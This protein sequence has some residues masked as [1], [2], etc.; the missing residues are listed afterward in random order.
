ML[1][2][3]LKMSGFPRCPAG[4][5][6]WLANPALPLDILQEAVPGNIRR[7]E[8]FVAF[9]KR[10]VQYIKNRMNTEQVESESPV[11]FVTSLQ[12]LIS[13]YVHEALASFLV[14]TVPTQFFGIFH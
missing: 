3:K 5:D 8:H 1:N 14:I 13:S 12:V 11:S 2:L 9:L 4:S 7:A 6:T 10:L